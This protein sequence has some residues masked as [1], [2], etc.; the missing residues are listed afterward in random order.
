M[1]LTVLSLFLGSTSHSPL[2]NRAGLTLSSVRVSRH[3]SPIVYDFSSRLQRLSLTRSQFQHVLSP[4]VAIASKSEYQHQKFTSTLKL[5]GAERTYYVE[6]CLFLDC[7]NG[8]GSGGGLSINAAESTLKVTRCGFRGCSAD[9]AG[10]AMFTNAA[11][12]DLI[13]AC[14][15]KCSA[16]KYP[17][18][19][20]N[21]GKEV[22]MTHCHITEFDN[23]ETTSAASSF[24]CDQTSAVMN[25]N[26]SRNSL[27]SADSV[28]AFF[29]KTLKAT[30]LQFENNN[31]KSIMFL[32]AASTT[33]VTQVNFCRNEGKEYLIKIDQNTYSITFRECYFQED[34]SQYYV[35]KYC[36]FAN[37]VFQEE[38]SAVEKKFTG[39]SPQTKE[40]K[41]GSSETGDMKISNQQECWGTPDTPAPSE[42]PPKTETVK[43]GISPGLV[44]GIIFLLVVVGLSGFFISKRMCRRQ[45]K[46]TQLLM[47]V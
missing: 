46:D 7:R 31:C 43:Q 16:S 2:F 17:G 22:T 35:N 41:F 32:K 26:F 4:P 13:S 30:Q 19:Y 6:D 20:L 11:Y 10:G 27:K 15:T 24:M 3:F 28:F 36:T 44:F 14:A 33:E 34:R 47:Y 18:F 1:N 42:V 39:G 25:S 40:C 21:A 12:V 38:A 45:Y 8:D 9:S 23:A 29:A 5:D 37:C